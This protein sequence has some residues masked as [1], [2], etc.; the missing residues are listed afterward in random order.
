MSLAEA[1]TNMPRHKEVEVKVNALVDEGVA[2]LIVALSTVP[3][4]VTMESCQGGN[5]Q[6]AYVFFHMQDWQQIGDLLFERLLPAMSSDLR[7]VVALRLQAYD[8]RFA[9]GSIT[10]DPNAVP[11]LS[12]CIR[13]V[14]A[15]AVGA[16]PFMAGDAHC[17][18]IT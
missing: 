7:S 9:R 1:W 4:L 2:D 5:G 3:G 15:S 14:S 17:D 11:E 12:A 8:T 18:A 16:R 13:Q 6:D 10:L